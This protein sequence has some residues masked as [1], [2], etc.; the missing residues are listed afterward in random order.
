MS[1]ELVVGCWLL[2][3]GCWLLVGGWWFTTAEG[4]VSGEVVAGRAS[5][6][7]AGR[8]LLPWLRHSPS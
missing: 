4:G 2:V 1:N 3:V 6:L 5:R 7:S 8:F